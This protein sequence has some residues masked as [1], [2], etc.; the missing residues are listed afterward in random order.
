VTD[1]RSDMEY[2][3][4]EDLIERGA[5]DPLD[6]TFAIAYTFVFGTGLVAGFI[7]GWLL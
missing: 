7:L 5:R 1:R 2:C 4:E 3:T 6:L